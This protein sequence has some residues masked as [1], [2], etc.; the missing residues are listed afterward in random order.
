MRAKVHG[1][2]VLL[3]D[4]KIIDTFAGLTVRGW[5][6]TAILVGGYFVAVAR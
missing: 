2:A 1:R 6:V 4:A 3:R 5:I